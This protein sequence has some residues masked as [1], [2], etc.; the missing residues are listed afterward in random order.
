MVGRPL[1]A[2]THA[3]E[4]AV[5][6]GNPI[7]TKGEPALRI[8]RLRV[9]SSPDDVSFELNYGE[10]V[11]FAGL[12]GSGRTEVLRAIFGADRREG[13]EIYLDG[14]R[15][16][17]TDP[18]DAVRHRVCLLTENRKEEGLVLP[19]P[20]RVN[21]TLTDLARVSRAGLLRDKA[22]RATARHWAKKLDVRC[23]SLEQ[24]ARELSG[25]NQQKLIIAKWLFRDAVVIMLDEPTRGIDV[26]A[27]AEIYTLLRRL[28]T[29]G[30]ALLVVSSE[31]PEL[32]LLCDR[33]IVLSRGR[34]VGELHRNEF[35]EQ[36]ILSLAYSEYMAGK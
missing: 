27:K 28:A 32:V 7:A 9:R 26:G 16:A 31:L 6:A 15:V 29:A 20:V 1:E 3:I 14:R 18:A 33:I 4:A 2:A 10:I 8:K 35:D 19:M 22:E 5:E 25:G 13:G 24:A 12:V 17:L 21:V 30:K 34:V 23:S 11:G 36:R